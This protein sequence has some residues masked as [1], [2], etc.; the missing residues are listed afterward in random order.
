M[1]VL[2]ISCKS[3]ARRVL[4]LIENNLDKRDTPRYTEKTGNRIRILVFEDDMSPKTF[5]STTGTVAKIISCASTLFRQYGYRKT[6]VEEIASGVH[7][8]KKTL[9]AI[10]PSKQ[11]ILSETAWRDTVDT[12]KTFGSTMKPGSRPDTVLL[13]LC[14]YIFTDRIKSGADGIFYAIYSEDNN[15]K[16][17]YQIALKRVFKDIYS[18]GRHSGLFKP[19]DPAY[20]ADL[21]VAMIITA[22]ERFHMATQPMTLF[23]DTLSMIADAVAYK[24]RLPFDRMR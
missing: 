16:I 2:R 22:H 21:I 23:N 3:F 7:V 4:T 17:A 12:I 20:A 8:S 18:E 15:L 1:R 13:S 11:E 9:Y 24:E 10:F 5:E 6:S 19:V 14:R